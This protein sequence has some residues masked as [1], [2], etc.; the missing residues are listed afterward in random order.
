L[1]VSDFPT[2]GSLE[3]RATFTDSNNVSATSNAAILTISAA[4]SIGT[5]PQDA[6]ALVGQAASESFT[7]A[8]SGG[9]A[10]L[11]VQ[12]QVSTDNGVTFTNLVDGAGV[13]GATTTT[14]TVSGFTAAGSVK[15]QALVTDANNVSVTSNAVTL[16]INAPSS[17]AT[18]DESWLGQVYTDFF[19]RPVDPSGLTTWSALLNQGV[20][21]T[22]VVLYIESG[23][24]YR[25]DVV[26]ALYG[27]LL[28][29]SADSSGLNTFVSFLGNGGTAEQVETAIIGS[30]EY[31]QLHGGTN[32]GFLNGVY[33]D[34]LNRALDASGAQ[35]WGAQL[36][37]GTTPATVAKAILASAESDTD[38]VQSLYGQFLHRPADASGLTGFTAALQ[39]G[40]PNEIVI[41]N[42]V[43]SDEYFGRAQ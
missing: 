35:S 14:L 42:I 2:T 31:F 5:Q 22:Q 9:T 6:T 21:R 36:A 28:H 30:A 10:P 37:S 11:V 20:S 19:N 38:E 3:Y 7:V 43:G 29:R 26:Q 12:W 32:D 24:E 13:A 27:K 41:A 34:V 1:T 18:P 23:T 8:V 15:Y 25:T 4:P 17:G 33:Q 40:V 16:T 39:Q